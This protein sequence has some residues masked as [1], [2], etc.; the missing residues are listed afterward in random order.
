MKNYIF[1]NNLVN[2]KQLKEIL[3]WTFTNYGSINA[4]FLADELKYLGFKHSTQAGISISIEDLRIPPVKNLMLEK[5]NLNI[6][7]TQKVYFKGNIT[8]VEC[9]QKIIDTWNATSEILKDQVVFYFK[10]FDPLNSV[11]MM[12]FSG[13]RGNLSQVRQLVGMRGLM[14]DPKGEIMDL[15]IKQNFR[16]GL[17]ITDYLMSGYGARKGIVDTAL[18]TANSGYLTRRLI[19]VAQSLVIREKDCGTEKALMYGGI[20]SNIKP[21]SLFYNKS[22]GRILSKNIYSN[23]NQKLIAKSGEVIN[24]KL[25]EVLKKHNIKQYYARSPL[26]CSLTKSICQ[27]CYGWDLATE[28]LIELGQAVGI[29]A[30]QSIG[31]PGT[32]LTMRTFHTG[33]IFTADLDKQIKSPFEG[34]IKFS[35]YL[36]TDIFR[37]NR[38]ENVLRTI[39]SGSLTITSNIKKITHKIDI[40]SFTLLFITNG[41][42]ILKDQ[43]IGEL[44]NNSKQIK[45]ENKNIINDISGQ[46]FC[47]INSCV[48]CINNNI[49]VLSGLLFKIP[50]NSFLTLTPKLKINKN[51]SVIRTKIQNR[52]SG[53]VKIQENLNKLGQTIKIFSHTISFL[54]CPIQKSL[55]K[56]KEIQYFFT[57]N[58]N[59][60]RLNYFN[61]K[62]EFNENYCFINTEFNF[63]NLLSKKYQTLTGGTPF[64]LNQR[65]IKTQKINSGGLILWLNEETNKISYDNEQLFVEQFEFIPKNYELIPD[66]FSKVAGIVEILEKNGSIQEINVKPGF[67]YKTKGYL[68]YDQKIFYPGE[69]IL[70]SIKIQKLSITEIIKTPTG[71]QILLR[72]IEIYQIPKPKSAAKILKT[73]NLNATI[74]DIKTIISFKVNNQEEI[75]LNNSLCLLEQDLK[76]VK[77]NN[78]NSKILENVKILIK[79]KNNLEFVICEKLNLA[80]YLTNNLKQSKLSISLIVKNNQFINSY[81]TLGYLETVSSELLDIQ[82][83]KFKQ[84]NFA[85]KYLFIIRSKDCFK[86]S[87]RKFKNL[88]IG[89]ILANNSGKII[90][91]NKDWYIIQKGKSY[92]FP[93][94]NKLFYKNNDLIEKNTNIGVL[95]FEKEINADIVQGLPRVEEMLEA[96][97][98]NIEVALVTKNDIT[99]INKKFVKIGMSIKNKTNFNLHSLLEIYFDYYIKII[100]IYN[101]NYRSLKK[102]QGLI[103]TSI[104]SVYQSQGVTI[105]DKHLE[106]IIKQMTN[107]VKIIDKGDTPLLANE[108][109]NLHQIKYINKAIEKV[110]KNPAN[111]TPVLLGITR[112]SLNTESFIS[113]ASFQETARVL[114]QSAIEGKIDWL[115][116]L[117]ENIIIGKL[118]PAGTGFNKSNNI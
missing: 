81:S 38:G 20:D 93:K 115:K 62:N 40:P 7:K 31:E 78:A 1:Q 53:I 102:I 54:H 17:N 85:T 30:G 29:I 104:Q 61:D 63:A 52:Y 106:V 100:P 65:H 113:A 80:N 43:V 15:P 56:S 82:K 57:S 72:P 19:D 33:G 21:N 91:Q 112:A 13:A 77:L 116:G 105:S 36:K 76:L 84:I 88:Y 47:P 8:E 107:K 92:F 108:L 98:G 22:L 97:N 41:A 117:K 50:S 109:I 89:E 74:F 9:F 42:F 16:E 27:K 55:S 66:I 34:F 18:K 45:I 79:I 96:R 87:K 12:A 44:V 5:S 24:P 28:N 68:K 70:H 75:K 37:T 10:N 6:L 114:T 51:N 94:G 71:N 14:S 25:L 118:I 11:Y 103:L 46:I 35:E 2:K 48:C 64:F 83:I 59:L 69:I 58:R 95:K 3:S 49:W 39:N 101:S 111:Y 67:L 32:Q 26:T 4:S 110:N 23:I 86:I 99:K 90:D 73:K 60:F